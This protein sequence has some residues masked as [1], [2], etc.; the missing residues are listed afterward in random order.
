M[1]LKGTGLYNESNKGYSFFYGLLYGV[2][3]LLSVSNEI[4]RGDINNKTVH[5]K[6]I[7]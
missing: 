5:G 7:K 4:K 2:C 1:G 6:K 3:L